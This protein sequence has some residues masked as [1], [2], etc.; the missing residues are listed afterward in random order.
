ME[1]CRLAGKSPEVSVRFC[2]AHLATASTPDFL[3][4]RCQTDCA[5]FVRL[6]QPFN[7]THVYA[8]GTGAFHPQCTYVHV[9]FNAQ[10]N[11]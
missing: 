4:A 6:L 5:N 8:C 9:S 11:L 10:V 1:R 7:K 2:P 3:S